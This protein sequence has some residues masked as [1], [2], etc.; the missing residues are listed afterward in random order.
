MDNVSRVEVCT[1]RG[2]CIITR[3]VQKV[4]YKIKQMFGGDVLG[5]LNWD[6]YPWVVVD[7]STGRIVNAFM[8]EEHAQEW[9][10]SYGKKYNHTMSVI[11]NTAGLC[12][13]AVL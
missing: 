4:K 2:V 12:K 3:E 6:R 7:I 5:W 10:S 8:S 1:S 13:C 9:A 11:D